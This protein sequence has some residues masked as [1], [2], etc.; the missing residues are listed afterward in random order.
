MSDTVLAVIELDNFPHQVASRA[1][2]LAGLYDCDLTL[3][4]SDPTIPVLRDRYVISN[5][6]REV[7][8]QITYAQEQ[9]L[10]DLA[11]TC[12]AAG[13]SVDTETLDERPSGDAIVARAEQIKPRMVVKGTHYHSK[14]AR[15]VFAD[16]DWQLIRRLDYPLWL[17]KE[18]GWSET[19]KIL[20]AVDPAHTGE[21]EGALDHRIVDAANTLATAAGGT[22]ELLHTYQRL[23]EIGSK[24]MWTF[25]SV[26]LP[27]DELGA[28]IRDE[29]RELLDKLA[30]KHNVP[31]ENVHQL[32]GRAE[33]I[34]PAFA[35]SK[36][37]NLVVM[38]ALA[39][40]GLK[41]RIIGSTAERVLDHLPCDVMIV[42]SD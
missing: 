16:I 1:A 41:R 23:E 26:T 40:S 12:G 4:L 19:P 37:I 29:H 11:E 7:A 42:R 36:G 13:I 25:K 18:D 39:R 31:Q 2:W 32:P 8:G 24:A 38:G 14:A 28:K 21:D 30:E 20:A 15:A 3:L 33:E 6:A 34:L 17:V 5:E 27:V 10:A 22:V 35:R 9:I